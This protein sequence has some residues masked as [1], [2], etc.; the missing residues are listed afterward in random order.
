MMLAFRTRRDVGPISLLLSH[1]ICDYVL[2]HVPQNELA[3]LAAA[4]LA[5]LPGE[6][7]GVGGG[8][9]EAARQRARQARGSGRIS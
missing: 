6:R 1:C 3:L 5:C 7:G 8:G 4:L 2:L 9:G